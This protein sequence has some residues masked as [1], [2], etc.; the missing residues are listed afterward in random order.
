M[1]GLLADPLS[2]AEEASLLWCRAV[3][4]G[5]VPD[6][7]AF[8]TGC[9]AQTVGAAAGKPTFAPEP[10]TPAP[11]DDD[12]SA[13]PWWAILLLALA[14][15]AACTALACVLLARRDPESE[16]RPA[17][18]REGPALQEV[19]QSVLSEPDAEES[20]LQSEADSGPS[21]ALHV[22]EAARCVQLLTVGDPVMGS[23]LETA[24]R[25]GL[26]TGRSG[27]GATAA[28][29]VSVAPQPRGIPPP[30]RRSSASAQAAEAAAAAAQNGD[31][32]PPP[33]GGLVTTL[34]SAA[35]QSASPQPQSHARH[36]G[37]A[38]AGPGLQPRLGRGAG[39]SP[40]PFPA[41][42]PPSAGRARRPAAAAAGSDAA[43]PR[44]WEQQQQQQR[45]TRPLPSAG[46]C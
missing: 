19:A 33:A 43:S 36:W 39:G 16:E 45:V 26:Q 38:S 13:V 2:P 8:A 29:A 6:A 7:R 11:G 3:G 34:L 30:R 4:A 15:A 32:E 46:L 40:A 14:A 44:L 17:L 1:T 35:S 18:Q 37:V 9:P 28:A 25:R 12:A 27:S 41:A 24:R 31:T 10:P 20:A 21:A 5:L 22:L 23:P 42:A